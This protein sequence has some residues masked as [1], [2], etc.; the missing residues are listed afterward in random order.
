[1]DGPDL[2]RPRRLSRPRGLLRAALPSRRRP[3]PGGAGGGGAGVGGTQ[4]GAGGPVAAAAGRVPGHR[5]AGLRCRLRALH[6]H[7][8]VPAGP[9]GLDLRDLHRQRPQ[10]LPGGAGRAR[11]GAGAGGQ[12]PAHRPRPG[13]PGRARRRGR[14]HGAGREPGPLQGDRLRHQR[15]DGRHRRCVLCRPVP[16]DTRPQSVR[17]APVA[18]PPRPPR[19]GRPGAP[20][21]CRGGRRAVRLRSA[22]VQRLRAAAVPRHRAARHLRR[23]LPQRRDHRSRAPLR[24]GVPGRAVRRGRRPLRIVRA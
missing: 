5:H 14:R 15:G 24:H 18:L 13:L 16:S 3:L 11:P 17:G 21:R 10:P 19:G 1:V 20:R 9:V 8:A 7:A 12:P 6:L 2:P 22:G 4:P 23:P